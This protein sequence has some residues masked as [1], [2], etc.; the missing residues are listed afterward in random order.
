MNAILLN[1]PNIGKKV[2]RKKASHYLC[3]VFENKNQSTCTMKV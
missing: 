2:A 3:N 1:Y